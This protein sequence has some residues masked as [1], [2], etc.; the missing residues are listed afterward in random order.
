M[1]DR[2]ATVLQKAP[3]VRVRASN[4]ALYE[5]QADDKLTEASDYIKGLLRDRKQWR[6]VEAAREG[7]VEYC[8]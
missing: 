6:N 2:T 3:P 1:P 8:I 7:I 5:V 4:G